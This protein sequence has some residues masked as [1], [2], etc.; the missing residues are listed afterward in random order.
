[1]PAPANDNFANAIVLSGSSGF[2]ASVA[3]D[4]ATTEAG[5]PNVADIHQTIWY[6]WT[7][8][9]SGKCRLLMTAAIGASRYGTLNIYTGA[10][11]GTLVDLEGGAAAFINSGAGEEVGWLFDAV[12]GTTYHF[13]L[14]V[15][16]VPTATGTLRLR[17]E[18]VAPPANDDFANA[19]AFAGTSDS[20]G[21]I[22]S[23]AATTEAGEPAPSVMFGGPIEQSTWYEWTAPSDLEVTLDLTG[24]LG[25]N[26]NFDEWILAVWEGATLATLTEI[27][28]ADMYGSQRTLIFDAV[29]G[30]TYRIQVGTWGGEPTASVHL[31]FTSVPAAPASNDNFANALDLGSLSSGRV[32]P[33]SI[34]MATN[35]G[36]DPT[37]A[38][39][40]LYQSLWFKWVAPADAIA[41]FKADA[42]TDAAVAIWQGAT[43]ATL[44]EVD[45]Q[46]TDQLET[47][48][49]AVPG[50]TYWIEVGLLNPHS[51]SPP[52]GLTWRS[53]ATPA[54]KFANAIVLGGREGSHDPMGLR[55]YTLE[56]GEPT[57]SAHAIYNTA[58]FK[59]VATAT[60]RAHFRAVGNDAPVLAA[61]SG[62][63][64]AGLAE[65]D[66]AYD[67][68][69]PYQ[70][71]ID[72]DAVAGTTYWI[73]LGT[74]QDVYP[75]DPF[76][77]A[78]LS[79]WMTG[80]PVTVGAMV[81][82]AEVT[83]ANVLEITLTADVP[84][85]TPDKARHLMIAIASKQTFAD[86]ADPTGD[87]ERYPA[88]SDTA[89]FGT[90]L[91]PNRLMG[92]VLTSCWALIGAGPSR[93]EFRGGFAYLILSDLHVG[94]TITIDYSDVPDLDWLAARLHV[95]EGWKA[96]TPTDLGP[97]IPTGPY[98]YWPWSGSIG[99]SM[100]G[101][102]NATFNGGSGS[103]S[104][105]VDVLGMSEVVDVAGGICHWGGPIA[106]D[107]LDGWDRSGEGHIGYV[108]HDMAGGTSTANIPV[109]YSVAFDH[110]GAGYLKTVPGAGWPYEPFDD[111][112]G[113]R[114]SFGPGT[115]GPPDWTRVDDPAQPSESG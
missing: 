77:D 46:R 98:E 83:G 18:I 97:G 99:T 32:D 102:V 76:Y 62:A 42:V 30:H 80:T 44:T 69:Y 51:P 57:P 64:L 104:P 6:A 74:F 52:V 38:L 89:G 4:L 71:D 90:Y 34:S 48:F 45:E 8:P 41:V 20:V 21:P 92:R 81:G 29:A 101:G 25:I 3:I 107:E 96:G 53:V 12:A 13:R 65:L 60:G 103:F 49:R 70:A 100:A 26:S 2:P 28:S 1:M 47:G 31:A 82:E 72:F 35:E 17:F 113:I 50:Q 14:G 93:L 27:G 110:G 33:I 23:A 22:D 43:L 84:A 40:F 24:S 106:A 114:M 86:D 85:S 94:D 115:D 54:D 59:W 39:A 55:W 61:Y 7:A 10:T 79:W 91:K 11:L 9:S 88:V 109:T 78:T 75:D 66:S 16:D 87:D 56:A 111:G 58:W 37:P 36:A 68:T 5:E 112:P 15:W 73:Q 67:S 108:L 95:V 19:H 105:W 63:T